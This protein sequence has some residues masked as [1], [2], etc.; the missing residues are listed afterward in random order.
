MSS[1]KSRSW[2]GNVTR[3]APLGCCEDRGGVDRGGAELGARVDGGHGELAGRCGE[4]AGHG[5]CCQA[6]EGA[7]EPRSQR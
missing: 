6:E 2:F 3:L 1:I 4:R 7:R 5:G